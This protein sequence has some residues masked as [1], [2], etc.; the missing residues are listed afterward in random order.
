MSYG[1]VSSVEN[2]REGPGRGELPCATDG[3]QIPPASSPCFPA[4]HLDSGFDGTRPVLPG[5][6]PAGQKHRWDTEVFMSC[7]RAHRQGRAGPTWT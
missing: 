6:V 4:P 3:P 7:P 2:V 5:P 1:P